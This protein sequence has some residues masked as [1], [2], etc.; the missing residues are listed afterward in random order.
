[1]KKKARAG[2]ARALQGAVVRCQSAY[3]RTFIAS[4]AHTPTE[5]LECYEP[6][7]PAARGR[8]PKF[9]SAACR[10]RHRDGGAGRR[11]RS[12][13][14]SWRWLV[15]DNQLNHRL[16]HGFDRAEAIEFIRRDYPRQA[17]EIERGINLCDC[18]A[19]LGRRASCPRCFKDSPRLCSEA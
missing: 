16:G 3:S 1:M 8:K 10:D 18:G 17:A 19:Y 5:C 12:S 2:E 4:Q 11:W 15:I 6:L 7:T 13:A 9:C 14:R